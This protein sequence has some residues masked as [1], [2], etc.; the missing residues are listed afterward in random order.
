ML[1]KAL[2]LTTVAAGL[3]LGQE[4]GGRGGRGG[5]GGPQPQATQQVKPGLYMITGAGANS[6]VRLTSGGLIVVDG[7]LP[8]EQNYNALMDQIKMISPQPI[9]YL[10]ATHHHADHTGNNKLFLSAGVEIVANENL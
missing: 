7:K 5:K 6:E 2:M 10:I 4:P 8:G 9:K 1:S 3:V